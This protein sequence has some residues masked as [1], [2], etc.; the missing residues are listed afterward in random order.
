MGHLE[1]KHHA[2]KSVKCAVIT[3]SDTRDET[4]DTSGQ[5]IVELLSQAG[6]EPVYLGIVK[7]DA[8]QIIGK[9]DEGLNDATIQAVVLNG[10]TGI[11]KHDITIEAVE[12]F[13]DKTLHGFGETFRMLSYDEI[14]SAAIMSRAL[15]GV[16]RGKIVFCIPGSEN[17]SRLA[18]SRLI[19]PELGHLVYEV[20]K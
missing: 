2:P 1:H 7:D 5:A 9:L 8:G 4:Q 14:G 20:S 18:V 6:H 3:V 13:L 17:A 11:G 16:S 10:G 12:P 19:A 15:A